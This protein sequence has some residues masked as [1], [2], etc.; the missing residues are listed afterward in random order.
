MGFI[1]A[2]FAPLLTFLVPVRRDVEAFIGDTVSR[3]ALAT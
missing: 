1:V 2:A 3:R